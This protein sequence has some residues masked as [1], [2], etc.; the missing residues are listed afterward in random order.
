MPHR[1]FLVKPH[2]DMSG[3]HLK[4]LET[5]DVVPETG[6]YEVRHAAHR[7]PHEV[8]ILRGERFP[9]CA[10]CANA[11]L[12]EL[13]RAVPALNDGSQCKIYELPD[14]EEETVAS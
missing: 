5:G 10:R 12:F 4:S 9:R 2:S 6:V 8:V 3:G 1:P 7:L 14:I 13:V 11:V